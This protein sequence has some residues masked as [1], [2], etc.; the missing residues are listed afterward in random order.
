[1]TTPRQSQ[2][3][4]LLEQAAQD[5]IAAVRPRPQYALPLT[6]AEQAEADK[7]ERKVPPCQL[8]LA[9][10]ALPGTPGCP[11]LSSFRLDGDGRVIEGTFRSDRKWADRVVY[12]EDMKEGDGDGSQ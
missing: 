2:G 12:I 5:A 10:H 3:Q 1:M 7:T 11:R 9:Y 4:P 8:C 6:P